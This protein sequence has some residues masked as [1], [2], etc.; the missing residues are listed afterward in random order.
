[1][2]QSQIHLRMEKVSW[3]NQRRK[4]R[5]SLR[6]RWSSAGMVATR[7]SVSGS[8]R[9]C[10]V[11]PGEAFAPACMRLVDGQAVKTPAGGKSEVRMAKPLISPSL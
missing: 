2:I 6:M 3:S 1:V 4:E 8:R 9:N 10:A 7:F 5:S 11:S